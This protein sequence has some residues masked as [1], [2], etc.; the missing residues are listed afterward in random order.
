MLSKVCAR[1]RVK[2]ALKNLNKKVFQVEK[3][4]KTTK[5]SE[6]RTLDICIVNPVYP[7][8]VH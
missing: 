8:F 2:V 5:T 7:T 6:A 4:K 3:K 1:Y